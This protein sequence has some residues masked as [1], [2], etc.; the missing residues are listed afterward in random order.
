MLQ[1]HLGLSGEQVIDVPA[2]DIAEYELTEGRR[3]KSYLQRKLFLQDVRL[4]LLKDE[5]FDLDDYDKVEA[6]MRLHLIK[7][8]RF[9]PASLEERDK[10]VFAA[11][12]G[13]AW[14]VEEILARPQDPNLHSQGVTALG[15]ACQ[16]GWLDI[17]TLLLKGGASRYMRSGPKCPAQTPLRLAYF[18]G[19]LSIMRLLLQAGSEDETL[20]GEESILIMAAK[21]GQMEILRM[22]LEIARKDDVSPEK[23]AAAARMARRADHFEI[24]CQLMESG[25]ENEAVLVGMPPEISDES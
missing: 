20:T 7:Q 15:V 18:S 17:A 4:R 11:K 21:R 1:V 8:P 12:M 25:G 2:D 14:Q 16:E 22:F 10:L 5:S 3:L 24:A 23:L 13:F 6:P 9:L 19:H